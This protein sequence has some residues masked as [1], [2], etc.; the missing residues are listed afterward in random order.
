[1]S[2]TELTQR[3]QTHI[4]VTRH[5]GFSLQRWESDVLSVTAP[6]EINRNDKGSFFAGSQVALCTLSGWALTTLLAEQALDAVV[7]VVAV[8]SDIHY[9]VPLLTDAQVRAR[10]LGAGLFARRMKRR[11]KAK[12]KVEVTLL[13]QNGEVTSMFSA[14]YY[15]RT[16]Q[17]L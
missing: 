14:V 13:N 15:A 8:N 5:L 10:T 2:L 17:Q 12:L 16:P 6:L 11:G 1:M 7:D 4:P 9:Q 3:I